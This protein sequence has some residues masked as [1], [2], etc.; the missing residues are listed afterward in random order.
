MS[1]REKFVKV[2]MAVK[3]DNGGQQDV[4]QILKMSYVQVKYMYLQLKQVG[5]ELPK[6]PFL[7]DRNKKILEGILG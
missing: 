7:S 3:K 6:L 2:W 5:V 1:S 4:G